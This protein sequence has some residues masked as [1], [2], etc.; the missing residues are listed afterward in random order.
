MWSWNGST[1]SEVGSLTG[2]TTSVDSLIAVNGTLYAGT[3]GGGVWSWNGST[4]SKVG[5]CTGTSAF[6]CSLCTVNGTLCAGT[7]NGVWS[8]N[9]SS[10]SQVG[11]LTGFAGDV[12]SL[13]AVNGTLYAG[14]VGGAWSFVAAP[15]L[16]T[17]TA[18]GTIPALTVGGSG[19]NLSQLTVTGQDQY[20]NT[21]DISGL[22]VTWSVA[23]GSQFATVNADPS[24]LSPVAAGSGTI[25]ATVGDVTSNTV[26][27]TVNPAS[28]N[29]PS[30]GGGGG[31]PVA[32]P[33]VTS[34]TGLATV[35]P[36]SGGTISLVNSA[37]TP[38]ATI[39]IPAGALQ[40]SSTAN[41][42]ITSV[43]SPPSPPA[44][45]TLVGAY[46]FTVNG[47]SYAFN[48]LV[49]LTFT[50]D[51]SQV[52]TGMVP[53]V[54]Y[55]DNTTSQ[56]VLVQGSVSGDTITATVNHFTT[57]AVMVIPQTQPALVVPAAPVF[58]DV[59]S[60]YWGYNAIS[61]L[62]GKGIVSGYPDG[63][64]N[65][66]ASITRAE[67]TTMLVKALG[68]NTT[69]TASTFTDV[70]ADDWCYSSV[71]AAVYAGLVS[72]T[73]D[74]LF[75]PNSPITREQMAV[76]VAH[77]LGTNAPAVDGSEFTSFSDRASVNSWAVTGMEEAVKAGI[78]S[79]MTAA[80]LAP[81]DNATRAQAAAMIYKLI[82]VLGK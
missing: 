52:P 49:T 75:A 56:W 80:M 68:L 59:T 41:V 74:H 9:G 57:F 76:M 79:G 23:S 17:L 42:T 78:V 35:T 18:T 29:A 66:D 55:Y 34:T 15:T 37:S 2:G 31:G 45:D 67:F 40:G 12:R 82:T 72:G 53:A 21:Y 4:W 65:P 8:W 36:S 11:S 25:V 13:F 58:S 62:S 24:V 64:F 26:D 77:A 30:G 54:E 22:T 5:S 1:W 81:N 20:G 46:D 73:G 44:G 16:A 14:T 71:N 70:T 61:S 51:P 6:V 43:A 50:F 3:L 32:P 28:S 27:F 69:G 39:N 38:L 7:D 19:F 60:S 10:W 47:G 63:T 33:P 48:S